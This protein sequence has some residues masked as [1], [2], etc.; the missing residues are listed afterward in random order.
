MKVCHSPLRP[1]SPFV[2]EGVSEGGLSGQYLIRL[3]RALGHEGPVMFPSPPTG[4][5]GVGEGDFL[6]ND[7]PIRQEARVALSAHS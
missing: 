5:E 7:G 3:R 6:S 4:G 2:G 1:L